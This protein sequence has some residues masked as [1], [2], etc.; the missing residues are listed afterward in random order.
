MTANKTDE[1]I[2]PRKLQK[3]HRNMF[4]YGCRHIDL[5]P[6]QSDMPKPAG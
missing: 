4:Y 2:Q 6:K 3:H 1:I 5:L